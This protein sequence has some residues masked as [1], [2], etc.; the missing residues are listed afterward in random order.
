MKQCAIIW[1]LIAATTLAGIGLAACAL[2]S[3]ELLRPNGVAVAA[4]G[5]VYVMDRGH[6]QVVHLSAAGQQLAAFGKLGVGPEE[7]YSGWDIDLDAAGNI[8]ICNLIPGEEGQFRAHD[9]VKVFTPEGR[10][11]RE[12]DGQDYEF[13]DTASH[14]PYGLD[15]DRRGRVYVAGFDSNTVRVFADNG[16]LLAEFFGEKGTGD[17]QFNGIIDVAVDDERNLLYVTDQFNSRVQQFDLAEPP[18]VTHRLT[19]GA[20]GRQAGQFAYPQNVVVDDSTGRVYVSDMANR[21][22]Q[23]FDSNGQYLAELAAPV[24]WQVIGLDIAAD[25]TVYATD[26]LNNTVWVFPPNGPARSLVEVQPLIEAQ[27]LVEVQ[28]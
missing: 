17:G 16:Q 19:F 15:I 11:L 8:Y 3:P 1:R 4:D 13:E 24:D 14:T 10:L 9:G 27:P 26:A 5:S 12:I 21:R 2:R 6:Q 28:P 18:A 7:I 20:Y 25:G 22:I 23:V